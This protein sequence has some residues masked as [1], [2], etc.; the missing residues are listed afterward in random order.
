MA[1]IGKVVRPEEIIPAME[2]D[3][4][5]CDI[6]GEDASG[7]TPCTICKKDL[8]SKHQIDVQRIM[9]GT[10]DLVLDISGVFCRE[11]LIAEIK[12]RF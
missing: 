5:I 9:S 12:K 10:Y 8:C 1:T 4:T 6:C 3:Q 11:C 2:I 7:K